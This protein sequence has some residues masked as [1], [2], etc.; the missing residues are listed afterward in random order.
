M[1]IFGGLN[2]PTKKGNLQT[3]Y[4]C[5]FMLDSPQPPY[6][7]KWDKIRAEN[8]RARDSHTCVYVNDCLIMFGGCGTGKEASFGDIN[9]FNLRQ[10]IWSKLEAL[11]KSPPP[12]EAHIAQVIGNDK[13]MIHGGINL[14][15]ESFADTWVLVGIN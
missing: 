6:L 2:P 8:P 3:F 11:G 4:S 5:H 13:M 9:K 15:E 14:D 12:R 7:Y 1:Y 10:K